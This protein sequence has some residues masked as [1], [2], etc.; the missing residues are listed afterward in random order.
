MFWKRIST[1]MTET[2]SVTVLPP[3]PSSIPEAPWYS[4]RT[5]FASISAI[6]PVVRRTGMKKI[7]RK[8]ARPAILPLSKI[9]TNNEKIT[10]AGISIASCFRP[11]VSVWTNDGS[12]NKAFE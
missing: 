2:I 10:I 6:R 8:A 11:V 4:S 5:F 9:A 1:S 12:S 3:L 7:A